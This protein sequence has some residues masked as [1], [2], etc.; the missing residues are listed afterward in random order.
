[1]ACP[2]TRTGKP[3]EP[4]CARWISNDP[5]RPGAAVRGLPI[6][7]L[8]AASRIPRASLPEERAGHLED[9]TPRRHPLLA[10]FI[11]LYPEC[12]V[13]SPL[14]MRISPTRPKR[15]TGLKNTGWLCAHLPARPVGYSPDTQQVAGCTPFCNLICAIF[16]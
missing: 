5:P 15:I 10:L 7:P 6:R 1:M 13:F 4:T 16:A 12:G 9:E 14:C 8:A 11:L 2:G 3:G